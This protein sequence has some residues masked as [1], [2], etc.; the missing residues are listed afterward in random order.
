MLV[1]WRND[2]CLVLFPT[3]AVLSWSFTFVHWQVE[4]CMSL[5]SCV[6]KR[7]V[8]ARMPWMGPGSPW[9]VEDPEAR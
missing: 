9:L 3:T 6:L 7:W 5:E 8:L 4:G 2:S 1:L